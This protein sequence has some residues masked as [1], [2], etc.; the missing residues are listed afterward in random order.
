MTTRGKGE[1]PL[2]PAGGLRDRAVREMPRDTVAAMKEPWSLSIG[3]GKT[4]R[5]S[6]RGGMNVT[7]YPVTGLRMTLRVKRIELVAQ[8]ACC[9]EQEKIWSSE[10]GSMVDA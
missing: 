8:A 10:K 1:K 4:K 6:D 9:E 5:R 7:D 3:T 2:W